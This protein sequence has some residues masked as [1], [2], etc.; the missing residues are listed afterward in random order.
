MKNGFFRALINHFSI[1]FAI[2]GIVITLYGS[3]VLIPKYLKDERNAQA[4][5]INEEL[6]LSLQELIYNRQR[7]DV[8]TIKT[9]IKGKEIKENISYPY[10]IDELLIQAQENF[11]SNRYIP[12]KTRQ[13]MIT[14]IDTLRARWSNITGKESPNKDN[15]MFSFQASYWIKGLGIKINLIGIAGILLSMI[16]VY[17]IYYQYKVEKKTY[18][19]RLLE[20]GLSSLEDKIHVNIWFEGILKGVLNSMKIKYKAMLGKHSSADLKFTSESAVE[21]FVKARYIENNESMPRSFF[22]TFIQ[23]VE[24]N[25]ANGIFISNVEDKEGLTLFELHNKK[26]PD[27]KIYMIVGETVDEIKAM[28]INTINRIDKKEK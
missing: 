11:Y 28:I 24:L 27:N 15:G 10:D 14:E 23:T 18:I 25:K 20:K 19:D 7:V 22:E 2:F 8:N 21:V 16:G 12:S 5:K 3:L 26:H 1:L 6:I 17:S 9:L 4:E 13:R